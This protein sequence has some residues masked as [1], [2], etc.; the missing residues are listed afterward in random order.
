MWMLSTC[1][2]SII[3]LS[4]DTASGT[5]LPFSTIDGNSSL[6]LPGCG[7]A[8]PTTRRIASF[9][10]A[11]VALAFG[12]RGASPAPA[13]KVSKIRRR[14]GP[15][16]GPDCD[17]ILPIA[18][19]EQERHDILDLLGAEDRLA[20]PALADPREPVD[21]VIWRHNCIRVELCGVDKAEPQLAFR[22]TR[23]RTRQVG[24]QCPLKF[25][26]RKGAGVTQQARAEPA[27]EDDGAAAAGVARGPSQRCRDCI[28]DNRVRQQS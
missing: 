5:V 13:A 8:S 2:A 15:G 18:Q 4:T 28:V 3:G 7:S 9:M 22:P 14:V 24:R 26:F 17:D 10:A 19:C 27:I 11:S 1:S 25:L 20:A 12:A 6:T 23:A 16:C 21:A